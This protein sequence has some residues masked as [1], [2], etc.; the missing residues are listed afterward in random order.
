MDKDNF[1]NMSEF[2][3]QNRLSELLGFNDSPPLEALT[4]LLEQHESNNVSLVSMF[5]SMAKCYPDK[6]ALVFNQEKMSYGELNDKANNI[7]AY[8]LGR[9]VTSRCIGIFIEPSFEMIIGIVGILKAG[10]AYLPIDVNNADAR[11]A[12]IINDAE[13]GMILTAVRHLARLCFYAEQAIFCF[14]RDQDTLLPLSWHA[15]VDIQAKQWAYIIYTSGST[16]EPKGVPIT[17][18]S[19]IHLFQ[20]SDTLFDFSHNDV[21]SC[22]HSMAFDFS[23]WEIWGALLK[24]GTLVLVPYA[25]SRNS[26]RFY[27]LLVREKV[28]VLNQT[29]TAFRLLMQADDFMSDE[30]PALSLRYVIFGG[31]MLNVLSLRPWLMKYGFQCPELIN[32]YGITETTV[33]VTFHRIQPSDLESGSSPIGLPLPGVKVYLFDELGNPVKDQEVGEMYIAG[34]GVA[35]GYLNRPALTEQKFIAN[36]AS[37]QLSATL[38]RSGDLAYQMSNG[39]LYYLGRIDNQVQVR[40]YRIELGEI[41]A[42][43]RAL[44]F[45]KDA[46]ATTF[47][48]GTDDLKIVVVYQVKGPE[49]IEHKTIRQLLKKYLPDYMLPDFSESVAVFPMNKN[50][51]LD[52]QQLACY[53]EDIH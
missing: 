31:E 44:N 52:L 21:W 36:A 6:T 20:A 10:F 22:F 23:V 43:M 3:Q 5:E 32:M 38:Y 26:P 18:D 45:V 53:Q 13:P 41:E 39:E 49:K 7:A 17:H 8:L 47:R 46:I 15:K 35:G 37:H 33:H 16:G 40:G 25:I 2:Q 50:G 12:Y 51:K 30:L 9:E 4:Q 27:E 19:V 11:V 42:A 1:L 34:P 48:Q 29:P 24:G 28:T 14:D